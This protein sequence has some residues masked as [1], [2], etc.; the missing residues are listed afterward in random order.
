MNTTR[1]ARPTWRTALTNRAFIVHY[2]QMLAAMVV[3][4]VV[5]GPLSML[6]GDSAGAEVHALLMAASMTAAMAAWM[7]WRRHPWLQIAEMGLAMSLAFAVLFPLH[8]VGALSTQGLIAL[9]HAL[10]VP[11]MAVAM[12][13]RREEHL[14]M[15]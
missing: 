11:A 15:H 4:M 8:W 10:M 3:G 7:T 12:L 5:L 13:R 6:I 9:G 1:P 14:G 2:L